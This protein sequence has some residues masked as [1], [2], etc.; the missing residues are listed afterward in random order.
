MTRHGPARGPYRGKYARCPQ[1]EGGALIPW[2][3]APITFPV[4]VCDFASARPLKAPRRTSLRDRVRLRG[5]PAR[6]DQAPGGGEPPGERQT[7]RALRLLVTRARKQ[8]PL[9]DKRPFLSFVGFETGRTVAHTSRRWRARC[10]C[11]LS[12]HDICGVYT[13]TRRRWWQQQNITWRPNLEQPRSWYCT[14][15]HNTM[16]WPRVCTAGPGAV[17]LTYTC[18]LRADY[19]RTLPALLG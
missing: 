15:L 8:K 14:T 10:C 11:V 16:G 19:K 2:P 4:S 1:G 5:T 6:G 3:A 9:G 17:S 18:K 13:F 12:F 7:P